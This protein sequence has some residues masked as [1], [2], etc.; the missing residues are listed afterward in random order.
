MPIQKSNWLR[1]E[2]SPFF[3]TSTVVCASTTLVMNHYQIWAEN[4]FGQ[5]NDLDGL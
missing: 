1:K 5:V 3:T 2:S 4:S